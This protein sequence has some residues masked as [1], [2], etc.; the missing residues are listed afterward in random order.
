MFLVII[1]TIALLIILAVVIYNFVTIYNMKSQW[2]KMKKKSDELKL[3]V[4]DSANRLSR[5][6]SQL[7]EIIKEKMNTRVITL[8]DLQEFQN[9]DPQFKNAYRK[10]I[11]DQTMP[12]ITA[13][14]NEQMYKN[15]VDVYL[16]QQSDDIQ[17]F[18]DQLAISI[19]SGSNS[20]GSG[21]GLNFPMS[22][23]P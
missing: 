9:L 4:D 22:L 17:R 23:L 11:V 16:H 21:S 10:Y 6:Q 13:Y 14:V 5:V 2:Q 15:K 19:R 8:M 1:N 12:A 7:T 20:A 3:N 18:V